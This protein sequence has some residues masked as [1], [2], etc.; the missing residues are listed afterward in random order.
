MAMQTSLAFD[1]VE[2]IELA[3]QILAGREDVLEPRDLPGPF[4]TVVRA[5]ESVLL[6]CDMGAVLG[7]DCAVWKYGYVAR[8]IR[9]IAIV[10]SAERLDEFI[11]IASDSGF[12]ELPTRLGRRPKLLH[13]DTQI[14]VDIFAG[15]GSSV[16][17]GKPVPTRIPHPGKM[18][19]QPGRLRYMDLPSLIVLKLTAGHSQ[20]DADAIELLRANSEKMS[21][22]R[23]FAANIHSDYAAKFD[24]LA[25]LAREQIDH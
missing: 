20:D 10:L 25:Q 13:R 5:V 6:V 2:Q 22:L 19:A 1:L 3:D 15:G 14:R 7:G 11:R 8:I 9:E 21:S 23:E 17:A 24:V 16:V 4:G 18:A 12:D